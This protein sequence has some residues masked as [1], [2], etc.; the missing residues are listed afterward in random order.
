MKCK[1]CGGEISA[2][3]LFCMNCG[4]PVNYEKNNKKTGI[5]VAVAVVAVVVIAA[6]A[7][8]VGLLLNKDKTDYNES[9]PVSQQEEVLQSEVVSAEQTTFNLVGD[10]E[11]TTAPTTETT[12]VQTIVTTTEKKT[13]PHF[14]YDDDNDAFLFDSANKYIT[15]EYL[16]TCTRDEITIIINEIYARHGYIFKD[17]ELRE[18]FNSQSW[19][20]GTE[21]SM[22]KVAEYFNSVEQ[23]NIDTIYAYQK[24]MGWRD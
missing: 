19:Y 8:A 3:N 4:T 12:T 22:T 18:Y 11:T 21:T 6:V 7:V 9:T 1:N 14:T 5:I 20:N 15:K 17:A 13:V 10:I 2:G 23:K 16:S 24:S